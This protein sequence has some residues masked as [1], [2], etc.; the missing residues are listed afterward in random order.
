[1][2]ENMGELMQRPNAFANMMKM[3]KLVIA[4]F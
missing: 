2:P 1:V 4:D 3:H